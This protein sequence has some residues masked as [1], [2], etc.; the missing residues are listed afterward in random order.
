MST[1]AN[2]YVYLHCKPDGTVFYVGKGCLKRAK[3]KSQRNLAWNEIAKNGYLIF[4]IAENLL[5]SLAYEIEKNVIAYF[6]PMGNLVNVQ[7]GGGPTGFHYLM[8]GR[9]LSQKHR[10]N[11]AKANKAYSRSRYDQSSETL[12]IG[13]WNTPKGQFHSLRLA[14]EANNC[15]VMTVRNRC[16]GFV[17]KRDDKNYPVG[18]K[19][20]WSFDKKNAKV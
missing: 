1:K 5:E 15:A 4:I 12:S 6:F 2:F 10:E 18:P 7:A 8:K 11:L 13:T 14:A 17:A 16:I 19:E 20:G 9:K 3:S